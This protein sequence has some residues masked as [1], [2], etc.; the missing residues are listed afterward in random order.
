MIQMHNTDK[1]NQQYGLFIGRFQPFH[2]KH[3][4]II[5]TIIADGL[6]PIIVIGSTGKN[7][8]LERNPL[9]FFQ[10]IE[11]IRMVIPIPLHN[12]VAIEDINDCEA[13]YAKFNSL[14]KI[15]KSK[16]LIYYHMKEKDLITFTYG[17]KSYEK[18]SYHKIFEIEG[19]KCKKITLDEED[20]DA[21]K[22]RKDSELAKKYLNPMI[23]QK[24]LD[25]NFWL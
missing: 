14:V 19:W 8:D 11:I 13:W 6:K 9:T 2:K 4:E 23:Y 7:R 15:N 17:S 1:Q 16:T 12:F 25:M 24:L 10:R 18:D 22:I 20:I 21:T 5:D 3:Q